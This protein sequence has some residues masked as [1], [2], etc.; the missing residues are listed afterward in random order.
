MQPARSQFLD[1]E[2]A[3]MLA[4]RRIL[5]EKPEYKPLLTER[6]DAMVARM[7]RGRV[8]SAES[9]PDECW[10]FDNTAALAAMRMAD[11][12]DGT[13]HGP[14]IKRWLALAK[15]KLSDPHTGILFSSYTVNGDALDGPEGSSIWMTSHFLRLADEDFARDQYHRA[16]QELGRRAAGFAWSR[17][18][19]VSWRGAMDI[20]SGPVIPVLD[21]SSGASGMAF[22]AASSFGDDEYLTAARR[23][24]GFLRLSLPQSRAVKILRKQPGWRCRLALCLG[25]GTDV[26]RCERSQTMT[27][28]LSKPK[29]HFRTGEFFSA[30]FFLV[31]ALALVVLFLLVHLAGFREYTTFLSGTVANPEVGFRLSAFYGMTY[32]ALYLGTVVFAPILVLAAGLLLL[33][34]RRF[35]RAVKKIL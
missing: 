30:K 26:G 1:S 24:A 28:E 11:H 6:V 12:L 21:I 4:A 14:F 19:P 3:M 32:I 7:E 13:D 25:A 8:L 18:W 35:S 33:W 31:R 34:E 2:I 23:D 15:E 17:E 9:Y 10:M 22:I 16:R 27:G 5:E 29:R 20:D